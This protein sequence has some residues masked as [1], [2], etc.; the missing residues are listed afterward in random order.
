LADAPSH[1]YFYNKGKHMLLIRR[2]LMRWLAVGL[3]SSISCLAFAENPPKILMKTSL[4]EMVI[5]LNP[6]K[7]PISVKNFLE[8][9]R[10]GFYN[11][12]IFHRIIFGFMIQGG[13]FDEKFQ[14]KPTRDPIKIE[15]KNGLRN[16]K[17]TIAMARTSDPDSASA[18]F[19]INS[20]DNRFLDFPGRDGWGYAVFGKVISGTEVVDKIQRVR[21]GE[22]GL[23][24]PKVVIESVTIID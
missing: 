18:Q 23:P 7:A 15:S 17:Y 5:E 3:V 1:L 11:G 14:E 13:G 6:E 4:G 8:Y 12:T 21:A 10:E 19:F 2:H 22:D 24:N 20:E 16:K 9:A